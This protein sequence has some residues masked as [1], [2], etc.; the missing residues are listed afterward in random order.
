MIYKNKI[1]LKVELLD[2]NKLKLTLVYLD[3]RFISKKGETTIYSSKNK[4]FYLYSRTT[5]SISINSLRFPDETNYKK[6][7]NSYIRSF[8]SDNERYKYLKKLNNTLME[9]GNNYN[10]FNNDKNLK[11]NIIKYSDNFWII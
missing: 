5:F 3:K 6:R 4:D 10:R 1:V 8:I 2:K 7:K 9:W 11:R